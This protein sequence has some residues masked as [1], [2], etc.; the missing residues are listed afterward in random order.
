MLGDFESGP[1]VMA[2]SYILVTS[3][4]FN[5]TF[6]LQKFLWRRIARQPLRAQAALTPQLPV[7]LL[8]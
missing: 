6:L 3:R 8:A 4:N 7:L 5:V 1:I 2:V